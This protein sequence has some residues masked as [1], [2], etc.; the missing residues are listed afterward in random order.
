MVKNIIPAGASTNAMIA[1]SCVN[2]AFK[3]ITLASQ[4]LNN[5]Y[6]FV[7]DAQNGVFGNCETLDRK[8]PGGCLACRQPHKT[9]RVPKDK[10]LGDI[11][12]ENLRGDSQLLVNK[13]IFFP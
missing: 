11:V 12:E 4:T 2:E 10:T 8:E 6:L 9:V 13:L 5:Y 1:A 3:L 7:G